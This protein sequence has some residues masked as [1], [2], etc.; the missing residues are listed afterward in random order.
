MKKFIF[1]LKE[2]L[3]I[4][5]W[6]ETTYGI[7]TIVEQPL[8]ESVQ[9]QDLLTQNPPPLQISQPHPYLFIHSD[10]SSNGSRF[11]RSSILSHINEYPWSKWYNQLK[12][13]SKASSEELIND[14]SN[15]LKYAVMMGTYYQLTKDRSLADKVRAK[16]NS[17]DSIVKESNSSLGGHRAERFI[18]Y[19]QCYDLIF[20][21]ASS[22]E[23]DKYQRVI[24][25]EANYWMTTLRN[26]FTDLNNVNFNNHEF[27]AAAAIAY[28]ALAY[29]QHANAQAW[30]ATGLEAIR[31]A[32]YG[33][34]NHV[35]YEGLPI[36][37]FSPDG[38]FVEGNGY[39]SY[40]L[41]SF[42]PFFLSYEKLTGMNLFLDRMVY[43]SFEATMRMR[44]PDGYLPSFADANRVARPAFNYAGYFGTL[45][46]SISFN[47]LNESQM[48]YTDAPLYLSFYQEVIIPQSPGLVLPTPTQFFVESGHAIFRKDWT[49]NSSYIHLVGAQLPGIS[50]H[51]QSDHASFVLYAHGTLLAID[52]GYGSWDYNHT[53]NPWMVTSMA[54]NMVSIDQKGPNGVFRYFDPSI[55]QPDYFSTPQLDTVTYKTMYR[56]SHT[57]FDQAKNEWTTPWQ[58]RPL[59]DQVQ[60]TRTAIF[61]KGLFDMNDNDYFVV[62]DT[63]DAGQE[64]NYDFSLHAKGTLT[65][66]GA[67]KL[68]S[69]ITPRVNGGIGNVELRVQLNASSP[70]TIAKAQGPDFET[71][72]G[73]CQFCE[74]EHTYIRAQMKATDASYISLL[75][76]RTDSMPMPNLTAVNGSLNAAGIKLSLSQDNSF[77]ED[78]VY[79][80]ILPGTTTLGQINSDANIVFT[81]AKNTKLSSYFARGGSNFSFAGKSVF[82][83][84]QNI[85]QVYAEFQGDT[86][87]G[88]LYCGQSCS[89]TF[90]DSDGQR[91]IRKNFPPGRSVLDHVFHEPFLRGDA[92]NDKT[93]DISDPSYTLAFLFQEGTPLVCNDAGDANDDGELDISD[94]V[95]TLLFLFQVGQAI[96]PPYPA[97]GNDQ[98]ED[99]LSCGGQ[100]GGAFVEAIRL[101][102]NKEECE[103]LA[104]LGGM[105]NMVPPCLELIPSLSASPSTRF[106][107]E[108]IT[109]NWTIP[110]NQ[111]TAGDWV[112][113][114]QVGKSNDQ[115]LAYRYTGNTTSGSTT[116]TAPT[117]LGN[118]E[119]RLFHNNNYTSVAISNTVTVKSPSLTASP[120]SISAGQNVTVTWSV[121]SNKTSSYDWIGLY[122][123]GAS[124][125][126]YTNYKYTGG[127]PSGSTTF[128]ISRPGTYEFRY[129]LNNGYTHLVTSSTVTVK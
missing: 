34:P 5:L 126:S 47:A 2:L 91:C 121:P 125:Y 62:I 56:H 13:V 48:F 41:S 57:H 102:V 117:T 81:R 89:I 17:I 15:G 60:V 82:Q 95:Y 7:P 80:K 63:M 20:D 107:G 54:H 8:V 108:T 74:R 70:M 51:S 35:N 75:Y 84:E 45:K 3:F 33:R 42:L 73:G 52:P 39:F 128:V 94:A 109:V 43:K 116:F 49:E 110:T 1:P 105:P 78:T 30:L 113:L 6:A 12:G 86:L 65:I 120:I 19:L 112:G 85:Q 93:V 104:T 59:A 96:P 129:L 26:R 18:P 37:A 9:T 61:V 83:S 106:P 114:Y 103:A 101:D 119:F 25:E 111:K 72:N 124:N 67:E 10:A 23:K 22:T 100:G 16:L 11:D 14:K 122:K 92:N 76:P 77:L 46:N 44:M 32:Y 55:L 4:I 36:R 88:N 99:Q 53:T 123:V 98:S 40:T 71:S 50:A 87:G 29:P 27:K 21:T 127:Q 31:Y 38:V 79:T 58:D 97:P 118:Y 24:A 66:N 115:Y 68:L 28:A 64:H 90:C 69:W